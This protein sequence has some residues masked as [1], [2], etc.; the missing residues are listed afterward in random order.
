MS[1]QLQGIAKR[2]EYFGDE[3]EGFVLDNIKSFEPD[4]EW[5]ADIYAELGEIIN[6]IK[7]LEKEHYCSNYEKEI[8]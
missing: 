6:Q 5:L 4:K 3:L 7:D 8:K 1:T 2:L